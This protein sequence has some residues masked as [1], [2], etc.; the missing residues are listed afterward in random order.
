MKGVFFMPKKASNQDKPKA[1]P[2]KRYWAGV[3]YPES[4]P[5]D[6]SERLEKTGLP[7]ALSPLHDK[8]ID[9]TGTPKKPHWHIILCYPGPTTFN[10]VK[11]LMDSLNAPAPQPL[12]S[13][14]GYYRYLTHKDNPDKAQYNESDIVNFNGFNILEYDTLTHNEIREIK[15]KVHQFIRD[16]DITEYSDLMNILLDAGMWTEYDVAST[17]TL[18]FEK[19]ITSSRHKKQRNF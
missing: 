16:N 6:W 3:L 14:K 4:V 15:V 8:D 9:P 18:F 10:A 2:K 1:P 5:S 19:Y 13:I 11:T 12:E 17:N 7:M